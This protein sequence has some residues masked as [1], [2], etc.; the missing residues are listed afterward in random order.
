M[1]ESV[2]FIY[3]GILC[4]ALCVML[5]VML[6]FVFEIVS[7]AMVE[8]AATGLCFV[9]CWA[10]LRDSLRPS[11]SARLYAYAP[12]NAWASHLLTKTNKDYGILLFRR[13]ILFLQGR[14]GWRFV[15]L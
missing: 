7:M 13:K 3:K 11:C 1:K 9:S 4:F 14:E 6:M 15:P 5:V 12:G 8:L 10:S 2:C